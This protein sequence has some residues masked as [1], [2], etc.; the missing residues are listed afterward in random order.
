MGEFGDKFRK[1]R[2]SK[3][4]TFDAV[5]NV[6]KISSRMLQ[7]IENE[8]FDQLPGGV[9]NKGFIRAYAKHLGL[10]D[11]EAITDYLACL[12]QAQV[13]AREVWDPVRPADAQKANAQKTDPRKST[14]VVSTKAPT[15]APTKHP[16]PYDKPSL[17]ILPVEI[18]EHHPE[19]EELPGLQLPRAED[20]RPPRP[21]Y[22]QKRSGISW[23]LI[24][25]AVVVVAVF[26]AFLWIHHS[27]ATA[28]SSAANTTAP[29]PVPGAQTP[30][31]PASSVTAAPS[32]KKSPQPAVPQSANQPPAAPAQN[33]AAKSSKATADNNKDNDASEKGDVT[34]RTFSPNAAPTAKSATPITLVICASETCWISVTADGQPVT[35]ETLIAP[36]QTT[37]HATREITARVGNAA[38]VTFLL[39]GKEIAAQGT[40]SEVKTFS[41]DSTGMH[42][43][44]N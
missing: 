36:A 3:N 18:E 8:R 13:D 20:A 1:A 19:E 5:A 10:N 40:E 29:A 9:F 41:F 31:P 11:E 35:H 21:A 28:H 2:E 7:A 25:V 6:T 16:L 44:S 24:A 39:N 12:R 37:V 23:N 34:I 17:N 38:G 26:A 33:D 14:P 22:P 15:K 30:V 4:L 42:E 32:P 43:S 27:R